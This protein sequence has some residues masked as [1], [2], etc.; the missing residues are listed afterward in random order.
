MPHFTYL[1]AIRERFVEIIVVEFTFVSFYVVIR[2]VFP[3]VIKDVSVCT[4]Y[5]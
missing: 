2:E 4:Q 1:R 3:S 5:M